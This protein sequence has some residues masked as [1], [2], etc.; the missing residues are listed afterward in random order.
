MMDS[1]VIVET[2]NINH[3]FG[4]SHTSLQKLASNPK[5]YQ[6]IVFMTSI[7]N[8]SAKLRISGSQTQY[9]ANFHLHMNISSIHSL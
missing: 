4:A 5:N 2:G 3:Y 8:N 9:V 1:R 7:N 6:I